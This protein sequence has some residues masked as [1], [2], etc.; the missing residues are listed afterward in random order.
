MYALFRFHHVLLTIDCGNKQCVC[1]WA[2]V[3]QI[4]PWPMWSRANVSQSSSN[5]TCDTN[6]RGRFDTMK[7]QCTHVYKVHLLTVCLYLHVYMVPCTMYIYI[8]SRQREYTRFVRTYYQSRY[9]KK[10]CG[11]FIWNSGSVISMYNIY[12]YSYIAMYMI[13]SAVLD[14]ASW[15]NPNSWWWIKGD[16]TDIKE[17]LS[18][19]MR[20]TWNGDVDL[21]DNKLQ[22]AYN[23][24][25]QELDFIAGWGMNVMRWSLKIWQLLGA[26]HW[27]TLNSLNQVGTNKRPTICT[28][29]CILLNALLNSLSFSPSLA[30]LTVSQEF[31][32]KQAARTAEKTLMNL[33]WDLKDLE[34]I[35]K[36]TRLLLVEVDTMK[37]VLVDDLWLGYQEHPKKADYIAQQHLQNHWA[38]TNCSHT[39]LCSWLAPKIDHASPIH[40]LF[41][42]FHT[43]AW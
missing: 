31:A 3:G 21:N 27:G 36:E 22:Q 12:V 10:W 9:F 38:Q 2:K 15:L 11:S 33:C 8:K 24:Y 43:K 35:N 30:L 14:E 4:A 40:S 39:Y 6:T 18:E 42:A 20:M 29:T 26:T 5:S 37:D 25:K 32:T 28:C 41:N 16:G 1:V 34:D 13:Q 17:G 23:Q 7:V 19:S